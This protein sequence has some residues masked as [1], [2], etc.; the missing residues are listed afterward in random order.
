MRKIISAV[1]IL[2]VMLLSSISAHAIEANKVQVVSNGNTTFLIEADGT[3]K[4]W[5]WNKR[6]EVG[7]G[8][9]VDQHTPV[10][11]QGL[12]NIK[13]I[14][15]NDY[16]YGFY[17]AIDNSNNVYG[18]G[19]N[20]YGQLGIGTTSSSSVP[21][22]ITSLPE[23]S[24][25]RI[26]EYTV[27]AITPD[28]DVYSTGKND[29]GQVGNGTK[30]NEN[31]FIKI[32][33]L[34]NIEDIVCKSNVA[35]AITKDKR[36]Y[37]W[38]CGTSWQIGNN[39]YILAQTTPVELTTLSNVDEIVTNGNTTFAICNGRQDMYAWGEG[40]FGEMGNYS[41]TS[42]IP[43]R[44]AVISGLPEVIDEFYIVNQT[45]F[46]LMND[47][48]LYGWGKNGSSEL[49]NGST[50]NIYKPGIIQNI[51]KVNQFIFNGYAGIALGVDHCVYT[52]GRNMYGII[53]DVCTLY[54]QAYAEKLT[55]LGNN[56]EQIYDG[57]NAMYARDANGTMYGWGTNS[58]GQL[59][60]GNTVSIA[61][62]AVIPELTDVVEIEKIGNSVFA[63]DTQGNLYG[64]GDNKYGQQGDDT[65]S[66]VTVPRIISQNEMIKITGI[67]DVNSIV[68]IVGSINALEISITHPANIPY[69][70]DPNNDDG[71]YYS[72]I[73]IQNNSKVPIKIHIESF[74]SVADG[75]LI[76][77]D[78]M[79]ESMD[80]NN[81]NRQETKSYIALGLRYADESQWLIS[82]SELVNPLYAVEVDDT[83]VGALAKASSGT[84][85]LCG[86][87]GL[88]FDGNYFVKHELV[89][90]VS[91][92]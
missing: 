20:G 78:V 90:V 1:F 46:A 67:G 5:G 56:I 63:T 71:F 85:T 23:I 61:A 57:T 69:S 83:Y 18:W 35:Y 12:N 66:T 58:L 21:T 7:N 51:P 75:D 86:L 43:K 62:P 76:L 77:R 6:G 45:S 28:G 25:I 11:I 4:G 88:A 16:G 64:W 60:I 74:E 49:G 31:T 73:H 15:P 47:G 65:T 42:G 44:V 48:T 27:Y 41:E 29:Y 81:L 17:F 14:I 34:S 72:D 32:P 84:L 59:A 68:P 22:Q 87:H 19:Y 80:W 55:V 70:I 37:A 54:R 50:S 36:V 13:E 92:L 52:W 2:T 3:V 33:Q 26:N 89:F 39:E 53:G 24:K 91:L 30:I 38:G 10:V 40:G 79:P 8:T 9:V 82:Q